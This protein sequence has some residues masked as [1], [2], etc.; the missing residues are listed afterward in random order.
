M[1]PNPWPQIDEAF[2]HFNRGWEAADRAFENM[3]EGRTPC[4]SEHVIRATTWRQRLRMFRLFLK[5]AFL[6]LLRGKVRVKL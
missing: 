4:G 2:H 5:L 3:A 6:I 1:K